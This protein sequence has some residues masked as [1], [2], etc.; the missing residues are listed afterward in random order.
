MSTLRT[1][2]ARNPRRAQTRPCPRCK[3]QVLTGLDDDACA[4]DAAVDLPPLTSYTEALALIAG[5]QTYEVTWNGPRGYHIDKRPIWHISHIPAGEKGY[6][7]GRRTIHA[8]H[9]CNNPTPKTNG[10]PPPA[11]HNTNT[12]TIP[13]EPPF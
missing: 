3:N 11:H 10:A 5:L 4:M 1:D 8:E 2:P 13:D 7:D 9:Q 12:Y 6:A